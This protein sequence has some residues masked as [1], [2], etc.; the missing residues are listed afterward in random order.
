MEQFIREMLITDVV[1]ITTEKI[2]D[3]PIYIK[4]NSGISHA[5]YYEEVV[6][7]SESMKVRND[8]LEEYIKI[9][10][11]QSESVGVCQRS[12]LLA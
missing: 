7:F 5:V 4:R 6:G 12:G 3:R 8:E 1:D 11:A 9:I 2:K 10:M